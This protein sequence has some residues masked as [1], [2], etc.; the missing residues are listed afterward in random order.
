MKGLVGSLLGGVGR[1]WG[2]EVEKGSHDR[3]LGRRRSLMAMAGAR[4]ARD[5]DDCDGGLTTQN[6][7]HFRLSHF[8]LY[9]IISS[10][11]YIYIYRERERGGEGEGQS[12]HTRNA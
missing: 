7:L 5:D 11:S 8:S 10:N 12:I 4:L 6:L 1:G 9:K 3:A 2:G